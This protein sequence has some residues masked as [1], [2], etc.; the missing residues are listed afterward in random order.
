MY[1]N[2]GAA[3]LSEYTKKIQAA[4]ILSSLPDSWSSL[5]ISVSTSMAKTEMTLDDIKDILLGEELRRK[6]L[7]S[8]SSSTLV[9]DSKSRGRSNSKE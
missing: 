4:A 2:F 3:N 7:P 5:I 9:L 6:N 8:N 1:R